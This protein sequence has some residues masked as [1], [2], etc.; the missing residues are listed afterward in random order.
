MTSEQLE[1][2]KYPIGKLNFPEQ[3]TATHIE[4][5]KKNIE[6]FPER[7]SAL[8]NDLND[9]QLNTPYRPGGWTVRQLIHHVADS[10]THAYIRFKW[11]LS[12]ENPII[13]AYNQ[14][15][16]ANLNDSKGPIDLSLTYLKALHAKL[17][18]LIN[19]MEPEDFNRTFI[20]PENKMVYSLLRTLA[21]YAW[22]GEHHYAHINHLLKR[23]DWK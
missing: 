11:T 20:H 6:T 3:V 21:T 9:E 18:Y 1:L 17:I 15:G 19:G 10:H 14:D 5:W 23:K 22:H 12:E 4:E 7:F 16:Y 13:K 2:L 8:V